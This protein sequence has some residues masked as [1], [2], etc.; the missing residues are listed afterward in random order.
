M[1]AKQKEW[2]ERE[3]ERER[4]G[5]EEAKIIIMQMIIIV[6]KQFKILNEKTQCNMTKTQRKLKQDWSR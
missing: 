5:G 1:V 2:K 6:E 3:R 4:G